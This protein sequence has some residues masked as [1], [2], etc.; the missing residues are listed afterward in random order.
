LLESLIA[1]SDINVLT[2]EPVNINTSRFGN[3]EVNKNEI[4]TF[5]EG[6]LGFEHLKKFIVVDPGD[7]T[8]VLW[9]QSTEDE[10]TA[11]PIIEPKIFMPDY[12]IKLLPAELNSLKLE[13]LNDATVYSI[14]TIPSDV[15]KMSANLKAPVIINNKSKY[16][17]QIVLQDS[18]LEVTFPMYLD[19]KKHIM[20]FSSTS[21]PRTLVTGEL[22]SESTESQNTETSNRAPLN[23]L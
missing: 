18:K 22:S 11:F 20:N 7:Q 19:L 9:L 1:I 15:T 14:L 10:S 17:R 5:S 4:I 13:N 23:E 21:T 2:E 16:S 6:L 3:L 12:Q 8:L